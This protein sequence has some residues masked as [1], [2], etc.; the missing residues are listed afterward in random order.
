MEVYCS[1]QWGTVCDDFFGK[2][3][4]DTICRQLGYYSAYNYNFQCEK[5][6]LLTELLSIYIIYI[7]T[8][9]F[10]CLLNDCQNKNPL[11]GAHRKYIV[12]R[13]DCQIIKHHQIKNFLILSLNRQIL[14]P[15]KFPF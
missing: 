8:G 11:H 1:G 7:R 14:T 2:S 15:S 6:L 3:D 9:N 12:Y 13:L 5:A 10:D 4:A